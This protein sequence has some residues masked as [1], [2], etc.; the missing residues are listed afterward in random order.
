MLSLRLVEGC[1]MVQTVLIELCGIDGNVRTPMR[2]RYC[3]VVRLHFKD[4]SSAHCNFAD[5]QDTA[6]SAFKAQHRSV[7]MHAHARQ[8]PP[9]HSGAGDLLQLL[10]CIRCKRNRSLLFPLSVGDLICF[11]P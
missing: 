4:N 11:L 2:V 7:R 10:G 9:S 3:S 6:L 8:Y 1:Q 5:A